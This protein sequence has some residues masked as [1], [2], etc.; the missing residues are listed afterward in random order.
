MNSNTPR[1][2]TMPHRP[3][4][5]TAHGGHGEGRTG[6]PAPTRYC[7]RIW[8]RGIRKGWIVVRDSESRRTSMRLRGYDYS[9]PGAYF[10]TIC[11]QD[12]ACLFGEVVEGVVRLNLAGL[13]VES[14]W[15]MMP[16]RFPGVEVDA[17]V[18][19]PNHLHGVV[20]MRTTEDGMGRAAGEVTLSRVVQWFKS[21]TTAEYRRGVETEGWEP[22]R[23][24]LWQRTYY[25]HIV[26]D[27]RDLERIRTY[28]EANPGNWHE[29][30]HNPMRR[31]S[32]GRM[33][34]R[35]ARLPQPGVATFGEGGHGGPPLRDGCA[36][37]NCRDSQ[38][39]LRFFSAPA[40]LRLR[41]WDSV[42]RRA[43]SNRPGR[44]VGQTACGGRSSLPSS[45]PAGIV[46]AAQRTTMHPFCRCRIDQGGYG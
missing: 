5:S 10:V 8:R 19:M 40:G 35:V 43:W 46:R 39:I 17:Y 25:D 24:R 12:R 9:V 32:K 30:E 41:S 3:G 22:F 13:V 28:I 31:R 20:A 1:V 16:G 11:V 38:E 45:T 26:R 37:Y 42:D 33:P 18:V 23:G 36:D 15:G 29:D 6:R 2:G 4:S 44:E 34:P 27:E 7:S 14:W 21:G